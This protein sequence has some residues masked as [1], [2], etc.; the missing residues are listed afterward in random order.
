MLQRCPTL[1]RHIRAPSVHPEDKPSPRPRDQSRI[2]DNAGLVSRCIMKVAP[3]LDALS[4]FEWDGED[5][6]PDDRMWTELRAR[7]VSLFALLC[8]WR[9]SAAFVAAPSCLPP[10]AHY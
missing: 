6:L 8:L 1:A 9:T 4:H 3:H 5:M 10:Q 7:C 2:R